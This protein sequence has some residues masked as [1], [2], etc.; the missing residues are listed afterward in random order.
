M[1]VI[2]QVG[3]YCGQVRDYPPEVA[4]VMLSDGRA[5]R[6]NGE[7]PKTRRAPK[8]QVQAAAPATP[9]TQGGVPPWTS[10]MTPK[11]YLKLHPTGKS[12]AHA[13]KVLEA[14]QI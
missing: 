4:K 3:R 12:A 7:V 10:K 5:D 8:T 2:C 6:I 14:Q 11:H 13:K 9:D 1:K